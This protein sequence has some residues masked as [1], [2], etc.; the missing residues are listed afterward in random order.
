M[1]TMLG[2]YCVDWYRCAV[3]CGDAGLCIVVD[4]RDGLTG[5]GCR[6]GAIGL[7]VFDFDAYGAANWM[8]AKDFMVSLYC[9]V[10][11]TWREWDMVQDAFVLVCI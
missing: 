11:L 3:R 9:A 4:I 2:C 1:T 7:T 10:C 5:L 8:C 6:V